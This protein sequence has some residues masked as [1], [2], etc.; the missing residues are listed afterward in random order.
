MFSLTF[1]SFPKYIG[2]VAFT[3]GLT[4][5]LQQQ[6]QQQ[7]QHDPLF[8]RTTQND[9]GENGAL[10]KQLVGMLGN[11]SN[12]SGETSTSFDSL[13]GNHL[14][15]LSQPHRQQSYGTYKNAVKHCLLSYSAMDHSQC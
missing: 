2:T 15:D 7:Q 6:Q 4:G 8:G 1:P 3:S 9:S 5:Q 12:N 14:R 13:L 11:N 10:L